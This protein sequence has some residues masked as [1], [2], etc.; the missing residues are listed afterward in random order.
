M[1]NLREI[2]NVLI[3]ILFAVF[4]QLD[5]I[6]ENVATLNTNENLRFYFSFRFDSTECRERSDIQ[7]EYSFIS[8]CFNYK[9]AYIPP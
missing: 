4:I 3:L 7:R 8:I 9:N 6:T 1:Q 2:Q 5:R